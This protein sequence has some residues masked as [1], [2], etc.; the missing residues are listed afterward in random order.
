MLPDDRNRGRI[1]RCQQGLPSRLRDCD[2][3]VGVEPSMVKQVRAMRSCNYLPAIRRFVNRV[4]NYGGGGRVDSAF[5]F[6]DGYE[7]TWAALAPRE[8]E[9][10]CQHAE[11]A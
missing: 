4:H 3:L 9:P 10:G 7:R 1:Q 8:L 5:R 2:E 11:R 6:L